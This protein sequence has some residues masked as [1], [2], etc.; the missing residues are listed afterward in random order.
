MATCG[1]VLQM[2]HMKRFDPN[3]QTLHGPN[4]FEHSPQMPTCFIKKIYPAGNNAI[5]V[6]TTCQGIKL[7][8]IAT[9]TYSD[10]LIYSAD[11]TTVYVR[12]NFKVHR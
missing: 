2:A 11:K 7:Y 5:F 10:L 1:L 12:D 9:N 6:G 4:V 3:T 8:D